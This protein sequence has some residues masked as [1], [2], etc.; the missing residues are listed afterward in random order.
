MKMEVY[1]RY[2]ETIF[3]SDIKSD[4]ILIVFY[5]LYARIMG[6]IYAFL[7]TSFKFSCLCTLFVFARIAFKLCVTLIKYIMQPFT[8][9]TLI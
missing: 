5:L 6:K 1:L 2:I 8:L 4:Q 7:K 3:F 9:I